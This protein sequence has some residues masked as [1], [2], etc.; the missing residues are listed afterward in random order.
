[1]TTVTITPAR[2]IGC[3]HLQ[4]RMDGD[5][6]VMDQCFVYDRQIDDEMLAEPCKFYCRSCKEVRE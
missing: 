6:R 2:C 5:V 4:H 3:I 1:M